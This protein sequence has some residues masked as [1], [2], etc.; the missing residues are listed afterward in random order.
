MTQVSLDSCTEIYRLTAVSHSTGDRGEKKFNILRMKE[1]GKVAHFLSRMVSLLKYLLV[2]SPS[3]KSAAD[4]R[5]L[6]NQG[7]PCS[8]LG[9]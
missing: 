4:S 6:A 3:Y 5:L 8:Q 1:S 2:G 9:K 7:H